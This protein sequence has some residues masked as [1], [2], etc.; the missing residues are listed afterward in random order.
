MEVRALHNYIVVDFVGAASEKGGV[1]LPD[2]VMDKPRWGVATSV[3][4]GVTDITGGHVEPDTKQGDLIYVL[5]HAPVNIDYDDIGIA[6][7]CYLV[8]D[9]D[10]LCKQVRTDTTEIQ[11]YGS[12]IEIVR[13]GKLQKKTGGGVLLP[14][15]VEGPSAFGVVK[16]LGT[17][18]RTPWNQV[19]GF[20]VEVGDLVMYNKYVPFEVDFSD[21]GAP[22]KTY[23]LPHGDVFTVVEPG[24]ELMDDIITSPDV[25]AEAKYLLERK[26]L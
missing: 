19:I 6:G 4:K 12:W 17:G 22:V 5:R 9:L 18:L 21:L 7:G 10:V 23:L 13:M 15:A 16:T 8:S 11:P 20:Q 25:P 26:G 24:G 2:S 14:N 1:L 3:G